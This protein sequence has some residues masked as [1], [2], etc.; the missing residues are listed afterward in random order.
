MSIADTVQGGADKQ[1][2][3]PPGSRAADP[4]EDLPLD[5]RLARLLERD[6][7]RIPHGYAQ[8]SR[9]FWSVSRQQ[10]KTE[11]DRKRKISET[12]TLTELQRLAEWNSR[13]VTIGGV[14]MTNGQAQEARRRFID[15]EDEYTRRAVQRGDIRA[16]QAGRF[17]REMRRDYELNDRDGRGILTPA[18]REEREQL[19][20]ST[21]AG[22]RERQ[23]AGIYVEQK[24][25]AERHNSRPDRSDPESLQRTPDLQG[26]F[27][28]AQAPQAVLPPSP[29][30][31]EALPSP[32]AVK[33]PM[34]LDL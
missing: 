18:E 9:A 4:D 30:P 2:R 16:D 32:V 13:K 25:G 15:N 27:A 29:A 17:Q 6:I 19:R 12:A 24:P 10:E 8:L 20:R 11:Q 26:R 14:E 3:K 7:T 28:T 5:E 22:A 21:L 33:K 1:G 34:G 31:A 23:I